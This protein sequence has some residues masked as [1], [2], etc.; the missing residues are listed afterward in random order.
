MKLSH[1]L[2]LALLAIIV[3]LI[4]VQIYISKDVVKD[5]ISLERNPTR[6]NLQDRETFKQLDLSSFNTIEIN[7]QHVNIKKG[8]KYEVFY[9]PL[10]HLEPQ[11]EGNKLIIKGKE[12]QASRNNIYVFVPE[13]QLLEIND[14]KYS[15]ITMSGFQ[16]QKTTIKINNSDPESFSYTD[17]DTD[18]SDIDLS[19]SNAK[20][21]LKT[22][23]ETD[24]INAS[25]S[26][27]Y[28]YIRHIHNPIQE[29]NLQ[30]DRGGFE[31]L[32][33]EPDLI[34]NIHINGNL[35]YRELFKSMYQGEEKYIRRSAIYGKTLVCDTLQID[36]T[37]DDNQYSGCHLE[38]PE[39][40][41]AQSF[42]IKKTDN[43]SLSGG[44]NI[45]E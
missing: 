14:S 7:T 42:S 31:I 22:L 10:L 12:H 33:Q 4:A 35:G 26:D 17:L 8:D 21:T 19:V 29:I 13:L 28:L 44:N 11:V 2:S 9:N 36:V 18:L 37:G 3:L 6:E 25:L 15:T 34:R 45:T 27:A 5:L 39:E 40:I 20:I 24:K 41:R 38:L 1:K 23:M 16:G 43:V 32:L 30:L